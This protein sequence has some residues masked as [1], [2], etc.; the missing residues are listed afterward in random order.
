[1]ADVLKRWLRQELLKKHSPNEIELFYNNYKDGEICL[2]GWV[3]GKQLDFIHKVHATYR[4][5]M[6]QVGEWLF[7]PE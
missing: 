2:Q 3:N 7:C 1:M 6:N 5:L 4:E